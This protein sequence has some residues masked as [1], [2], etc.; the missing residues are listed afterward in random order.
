VSV[1]SAIRAALH[2]TIGAATTQRLLNIYGDTR[3]AI[4]YAASP[5]GRRS[6]RE[7]RAMRDRYRGRRAFIIGNGPSLR[8]MDLSPLRNEVTFGLNRIY[9]L[10][11][12]MGFS[13]TFLVSVNIHVIEQ[14]AG[15]LAATDA[16]QIFSWLGRK[17]IERAQDV[18][19][20]RPVSTPHF[21]RDPSSGLWEG[22]TVTFV[23]MQ[24]A[25]HMGFDEVILIGV[26]H[27]FASTGEPH[28]L[29]TSRG[30]DESHFDP[31]YFGKGFRW[32]LPDLE[33]SEVAYQLALRAF[34][35]DG[36]RVLNATVGGRLE[37]FPRVDYMTLF[38]AA[39]TWS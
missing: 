20:V 22:A 7:L 19:F 30:A 14:C 4:T 3:S 29:V 15:E 2:A 13:T 5:D 35:A 17:Y 34:E 9:L 36:R 32:Q 31:G 1:K 37:V 33:T 25:Y 26:D 39:S 10:F 12:R 6:G 21:A 8:D 28:A 38:D 18:T 23:A 24:L 11:E 27:R 16:K